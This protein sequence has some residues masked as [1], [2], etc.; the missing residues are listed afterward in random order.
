MNHEREQPRLGDEG[1]ETG[2]GLDQ[3]SGSESAKR[4]ANAH[5]A[6]AENAAQLVLARDSVA[7]SE[8][9][10]AHIVDDT[11]DDGVGH[12]HAV[13]RIHATTSTTAL[14]S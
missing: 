6:D 4:F 2:L 8:L 9:T 12:G 1:T 11:L 3:A 7:W 14:I 13:Q 5:P 10:G